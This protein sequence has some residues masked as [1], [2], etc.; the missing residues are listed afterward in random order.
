MKRI[1]LANSVSVLLL[2]L[3]IYSATS[4]FLE[5]DKFVFQMKLAP[6][7]LMNWSAPVLG[8]LIPAIETFLVIGL[9]AGMFHL[10]IQVKTLYA[11]VILLFVFEFYISAML[12]SGL[13]L[14]CTC[15]GII[16]QMSWWQHLLFN[17][18]FIIT[19]VFSIRY[20]QKYKAH[21][22]DKFGYHELKRT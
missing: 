3:F 18:F 1:P 8:W 10:V 19:G 15:G 7:P 11:S 14:P 17:A 12:L 6:V 21:P 13:E 9:A 2:L 5:Y 22:A 4:K 20:S 16:S